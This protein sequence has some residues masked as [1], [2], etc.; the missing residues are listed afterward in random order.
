MSWQAT[1]RVFAGTCTVAL[2][3]AFML[4]L[5]GAWLVLPFA[6]LGL[7]GLGL[8]LHRCAARG[9][10]REVISIEGDTVAIERGRF[11]PTQRHEL[12]R[13]WTRVVLDRP[14]AQGHPSRLSIRA[15]DRSV[16]VGAWLVEE[17]RTWLAREL[18]HRL[19][20]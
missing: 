9:C 13:S 18:R 4:A 12:P 10:E 14:D 6:G 16:E 3:I 15:H 8:G 7:A 20:A 1:L 5:A 19:A 2:T 11:R 17:E